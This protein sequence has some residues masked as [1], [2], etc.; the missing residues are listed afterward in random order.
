TSTSTG[1]A[2]IPKRALEWTLAT[3]FS[4]FGWILG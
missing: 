4:S 2:S 1:Y 3:I